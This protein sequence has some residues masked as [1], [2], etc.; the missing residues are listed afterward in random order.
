MS[1]NRT[2]QPIRTCIVCRRHIGKN[3]MSRYVW[4]PKTENVVLDTSQSMPGRGAYCC[5]DES[6][7]Q[8]FQDRKQG[9]KRA[10]RLN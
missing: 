8:R 10:F 3:V 5:G 6:C 4:N 7:R 1:R 2:A 9:W